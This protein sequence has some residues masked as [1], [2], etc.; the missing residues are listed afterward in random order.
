MSTPPNIYSPKQIQ[1]ELVKRI[2][3]LVGNRLYQYPNGEAAVVKS[4][5]FEKSAPSP[6][7]PYIAVD[8]LQTI[9]PYYDTKFEGWK[10]DTDYSII[11]TKIMQFIIRVY[12]SG[13]DDT[14]SIASE[15]ATRMKMTN[16][17]DYFD[18]NFNVQIYNVTN[19]V[20]SSIRTT[21][22]YRDIAT[23]NMSFAYAE[24]YIEQEDDYYKILSV[25]I[26]TSENKDP[27]GKAGLYDGIDDPD[28]LQI[29]TGD[30]PPQS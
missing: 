4:N 25:N 6:K 1:G 24:E 29:E 11:E 28:P 5:A 2:K 27:D 17:N 22:E 7:M 14:L 9:T 16:N 19:P 20:T 30:L 21:D 12:G 26:D 18:L 10:N 13:E 8:F 3:Q 23:F 15:L